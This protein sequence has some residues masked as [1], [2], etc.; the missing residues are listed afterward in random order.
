VTPTINL[1]R[2]WP[3][4]LLAG[5]TCLLLL[6]LAIAVTVWLDRKPD[7]AWDRWYGRLERFPTTPS[8]VLFAMTLFFTTGMVVAGLAIFFAW[9]GK[10][11]SNTL[12]VTLDT[13][14]DKVLILSTIS[15]VH[16]IGKRA[17]EKSLPTET[18]SPGT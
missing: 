10:E 14:L 16:F 15:T 3:I 1:P 12:V 11:P 4:V 5:V 7:E 2:T 18:P 6:L 13:W 17:T 9:T 8:L